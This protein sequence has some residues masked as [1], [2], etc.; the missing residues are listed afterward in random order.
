MDKS[1]LLGDKRLTRELT[2]IQSRENKYKLRSEVVTDSPHL[3]VILGTID[4][5][6]AATSMGLG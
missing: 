4:A 6:L 2:R 3:F 1:Q 5:L